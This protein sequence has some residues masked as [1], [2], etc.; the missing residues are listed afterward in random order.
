MLDA[1][2]G[3]NPIG[4][5]GFP[6]AVAPSQGSTPT[7]TELQTVQACIKELR[8][9]GA[10]GPVVPAEVQPLV[11]NSLQLVS[12][13][14][15]EDIADLCEAFVDLRLRL[16]LRDMIPAVTA[17]VTHSGPDALPS[18]VRVMGATGKA[19]LYFSELF[20]FCHEHLH[21]LAPRDLAAYVYESGR[22]G[23]RGRHFLEAAGD[24]A[25][26]LLPQ[27]DLTDTM[28]AWQGFVRFSRDRRNYYIAA[29]P[30]VKP[31]IRSLTDHQ[32]LLALRAARDLK[33]FDQF[34]DL[35]AACASEATARV[36]RL[37]LSETALCLLQC[38]YS[39]RFR[40]QAHGLVRSVEQ[41]WGR[42]EDLSPLRIVEVVDSLD[43]FA[44]WGM[45]PVALISRLDA[46]LVER[47][48]E[49]KYAGN[50][51]LWVTATSAFARM[52]HVD[53]R[54]PSVALEFARDKSFVERGSFFQ[55]AAL[56][57]SLG[58]LRFFD[59]TV[60]RNVAE[61][62]CADHKLF[63]TVQDLAQV[64]WAYATV[65][66]FHPELFD[67][68]YDLVLEWLEAEELD[69]SKPR[70][71][72]AL[73]QIAWSFAVAGYHKRHESYAALLDYV[74]FAQ[75][76][77]VRPAQ[78]RRLAQLADAVLE[79]APEIAKLC[80]YPERLAEA[81]TNP[82]VRSIVASDPVS[83]PQ[84]MQD[85]RRALAELGWRF[86]AFLVPDGTS[87]FYVD[88]SLAPKVGQNVGLMLG[89]RYEMLRVGLPHEEQPP[90]ESGLLMLGRRLLAQRGWK[91]AVITQDG[92]DKLNGPDERKA[93]LEKA[94]QQALAA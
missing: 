1:A 37:S 33:H 83:C 35:H 44:S 50:V 26:E 46:F 73:A 5:P 9:R 75:P 2:P 31:H 61:L 13:A 42:T 4:F 6:E 53:A 58:R 82:R 17:K 62:L 71:Q 15:W 77:S 12:S 65:H 23:L 78:H 36:D 85:L 18:V 39:P 32:L 24:R 27:M 20:D 16:P 19:S 91:T 55:Q 21:S 79:E 57:G 81:R 60:Y 11:H 40:S 48:V 43:V 74:F 93:L 14:T 89:G 64:L 87:A 59:E 69:A 86:D 70:T 49:L 41:R 22:H 51:S 90:R 80:Q 29:E 54:W 25:A 45:K 47:Q 66:Y 7:S 72:I 38:S 28:R 94:V 3:T 63:K 76:A 84:L 30:R 67:C 10:G 56:I 52:E 88:V 68:A 8:Q 34:I 92:W